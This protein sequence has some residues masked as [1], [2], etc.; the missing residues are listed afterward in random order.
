VDTDTDKTD[1]RQKRTQPG[2]WDSWLRLED[3]SRGWSKDYSREGQVKTTPIEGWV[4]KT[5]ERVEQRRLQR[6]SRE[7][8]PNRRSSKE[9]SSRGSSEEDRPVLLSGKTPQ[10]I[11]PVTVQL[12]LKSGQESQRG[13]RPRRTDRLTN[14]QL[15]SNSAQLRSFLIIVCSKCIWYMLHESPNCLCKYWDEPSQCE[16]QELCRQNLFTYFK[17][18]LH[19]KKKQEN[20]K[21]L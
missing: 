11:N 15:Q 10:D 4:K 5:P 2:H 13:S 6:G 17:T 16:D 8:D 3:S 21:N 1:D 18:R 9:D 7:D 12:Q 20:I 19:L 14:C